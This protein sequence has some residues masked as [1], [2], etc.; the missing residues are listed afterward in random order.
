MEN[1]KSALSPY[2]FLY[3]PRLTTYPLLPIPLASLLRIVG[4]GYLPLDLGGSALPVY[5]PRAFAHS[6]KTTLT[7]SLT[8]L[9]I[10]NYTSATRSRLPYGQ[11]LLQSCRSLLES[12]IWT[13]CWHQ[14]PPAVFS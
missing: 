8:C 1:T 4:S 9:F 5:S 6:T 7:L 14:P 13:P 11:L 12:A 10:P 2:S 3:P